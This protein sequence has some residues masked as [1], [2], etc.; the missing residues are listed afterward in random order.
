MEKQVIFRDRQEFQAADP[1][2][3]QD[4][5][6]QSLQ[7]L[8]ADA[9][10]D[11]QNYAG[12]AVSQSSATEISVAAG[13][14]YD[15]G[16][17]YV[18]DDA[19]TKDLFSYL[20]LAQQRIV[21]VVVWGSEIE[22]DVEPRDFLIDLTNGTTEPQAV[23]MTRLEQAVV[24]LVSG[25][26]SVDPQAPSAGTALAVA[27]V[28]L[29]T[30]GITAIEMV[31]AN[32]LPQTRDIDRR[33]GT[34]ETW[35]D[36][37]EPRITSIAT[38]LAALST[39]TD[40]L[41]GHATLVNLAS[42]IADLRERLDIPDSY[43]GW[44]ADRFVDDSESD[45]TQ[46]GYSCVVEN[47]LRFGN[48]GESTAPVALLNP[49]DPNT[50]RGADDQVLPDFE[51]E[52]R[53]R[54]SGYAG[55]IAINAYPSYAWSWY[56]YARVPW[57]YHYGWCWN[58]YRPW[59]NSWYWRHYGYSY[60]YRLRSRYWYQRRDSVYLAGSTPE[61]GTGSMVAQT[62]LVS[63]AMWLSRVGIYLTAVASGSNIQLLIA[64]TASG[65]P[66]LSKAVARVT[67][68]SGDLLPYPLETTIDIGPAYLE[69]GK[70]YALV[71]I[72]QGAHQLAV[73]SGSSYT[74]GTIFYG[75]DGDY[76]HG[77]LSKD[78]MFALYG[79]KFS[80]PRV[81]VPLQPASLAGGLTDID[82]EAEQVVPEG[83][84]L[85]YEIQVDGKW[86]PLA[87][88]V[89]LLS[90]GSHD[91]VPLRAVFVG[92]SDLA[93]AVVLNTSGL[94]ASRPAESFV[95]WS[96]ERTLPSWSEDIEVRLLV[97]DWDAVNHSIDVTLEDGTTYSATGAPAESDENGA[98]RFVFSFA[99]NPGTGISSYRIKI[100]GTRA[101]GSLPFTVTERV[102][103]AI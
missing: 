50:Y 9:V 12:F 80:Y 94:K 93:A 92:T 77:D 7:D 69:A 23:A 16:A 44:G 101:A 47:G 1:N 97:A 53:L 25:A 79:A 52:R 59:W 37:A 60:W 32:E 86:R 43:S 51:P 54:T 90:G 72:S 28:T 33:L 103:I 11:G 85:S 17:Q 96:A 24:D 26:E 57:R 98:R 76:L 74:Q 29:D 35:R 71:L 78:L 46:A 95:H 21:A 89:D 27:Y 4:Y 5:V 81:E 19:V 70:R 34:V 91:L 99:P 102:D 68:A 58:W 40:G 100:A 73:V 20:P 64:E 42:D 14:L 87:E 56:P 62:F 48:A 8:T 55:A 83:T 39:K 82:I 66:D 41:A 38:D 67:V 36:G 18:S 10:S 45:D 65:V 30:S 13:R 6:K 75:T 3:L 2:N 84:E 49:A 63:N 22:T 88:D 61:N 31:A 15:A